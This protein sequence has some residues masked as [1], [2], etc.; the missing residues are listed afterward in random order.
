[1]SNGIV[2]NY[3]LNIIIFI[4]HL[5]LSGYNVAAQKYTCFAT[6]HT[7]GKSTVFCVVGITVDKDPVIFTSRVPPPETVAPGAWG[8][9]ESVI[10]LDPAPLARENF[11]TNAA[12]MLTSGVPEA[13]IF[14]PAAGAV[15]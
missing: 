12:S 7:A 10:S 15:N 2:V 6:Y 13:E 4:I 5:D 9:C 3:D 8:D 11:G 14:V 1:M